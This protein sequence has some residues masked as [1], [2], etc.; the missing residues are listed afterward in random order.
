MRTAKKSAKRNGSELKQLEARATAACPVVG[1][2]LR[3]SDQ[4][5]RASWKRVPVDLSVNLDH[6]LYGFP[7]R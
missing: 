2:L 4:V 5:P 1:K 6:Y 3:I 7:K